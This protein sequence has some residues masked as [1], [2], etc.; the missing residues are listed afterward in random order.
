MDSK[1]RNEIVLDERKLVAL[2]RRIYQLERNN[3]KSNKKLKDN[4]MVDRIIRMITQEVD[5]VN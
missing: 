1:D 5:N 3:E 4:D 2:K